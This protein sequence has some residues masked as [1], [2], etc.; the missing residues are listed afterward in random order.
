MID[1]KGNKKEAKKDDLL[2]DKLALEKS[3][4]K[5]EKAE[6]KK[7]PPQQTTQLKGNISED[8]VQKLA[9]ENFDEFCRFQWPL[10]HS[11]YVRGFLDCRAIFEKELKK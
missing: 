1:E 2:D 5:S 6:P 3:K 8:G 7:L 11:S 4:E 9:R 10:Y